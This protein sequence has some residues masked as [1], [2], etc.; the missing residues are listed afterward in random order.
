MPNGVEGEVWERVQRVLEHPDVIAQEV[1]RQEARA[2]EQ[3]AELQQEVA[4]LDTA[5]AKM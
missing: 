4:C 5:L 1:A 2:E 3:R